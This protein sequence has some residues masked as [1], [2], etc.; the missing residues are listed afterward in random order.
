MPIEKEKG[1][2]IALAWPETRVRKVG[3]WYDWVMTRLG[4]CRNNYYVAGHAALV[5][6]YRDQFL[7]YDFGRYH[8]PHQYGRVRSLHTDP[9]L[10]VPFAPIIDSCGQVHNM[11]RLL[12]WLS[13]HE[14]CHGQGV[15]YAGVFNG[16]NVRLVNEAVLALQQRELVPYGPF[17]RGGS[18]CSRFVRDAL[19]CGKPELVHRLVLATPLMLTPTP[20]W[21]TRCSGAE[22]KVVQQLGASLEAPQPCY[23]TT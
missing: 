11:N 1:M 2:A 12:D 20:R 14:P 15:L 23:G 3:V 18:N 22:A 16:I 5:V 7:Y 9:E 21:N 6:V 10:Q 19:L 13:T 4:I 17:V 8:T